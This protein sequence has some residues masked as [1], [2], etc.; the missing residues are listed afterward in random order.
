MVANPRTGETSARRLAGGTLC[1]GPVRAAGERVILGGSRGG[2][3]VAL[4]LPLTLTG[5]AR[6]LGVAEA[7]A[8]LTGGG[9]RLLAWRDGSERPVRS[10]SAPTAR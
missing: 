10:R 8:P 6:S 1:P 5:R 2:R 7:F 9:P 3:A 4:S